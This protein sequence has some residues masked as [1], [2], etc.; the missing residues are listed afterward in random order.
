M[1]SISFN[2]RVLTWVLIGFLVLMIFSRI[3]HGI[4]FIEEARGYKL[5]GVEISN[6]LSPN[7][8]RT[9]TLFYCLLLSYIVFQLK[10]F[11]DVMN[12]F[13]NDLFFSAKNGVQLKRI[14]N[15]ILFFTILI[16]IIK[17]FLELYSISSLDTSEMLIQESGFRKG[18]LHHTG[19][20]FGQ[21]VAKICFI[22]IPLFIISQILS[23]QSELV[24]K[25]HLLKSEND[26]TI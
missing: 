24:Q 10:K 19:Y 15:G 26:L 16:G 7:V 9:L 3:W 21:I 25:G 14:A 8:F 13:Y 23:L 12:D 20:L 2:I 6:K 5:L 22:C 11:N 17:L 4:L 18:H 1:K